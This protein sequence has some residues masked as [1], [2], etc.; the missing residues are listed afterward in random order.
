[1]VND[2]KLAASSRDDLGK[3]AARKLRAAGRIPA[4]VYGNGEGAQSLSLDGREVNRL[5]ANISIDNT[6]IH[7]TVDD[8]KPVRV[9]VR[10]VQR[11]PWRSEILHVD[12][13]QVRAGETVTVEVPVRLSGT[14]AGVR[15][16]GVLDQTLYD[17]AVRCRV[18]R[19]PEAIDID[20]SGLNVGDTLYVSDLSLPEGVE[21][22]VEG[23][24]VV[25]SVTP[26]T[27]SAVQE[28][29]EE[30]EAEGAAAGEATD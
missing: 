16:G 11:H 1:M 20:V 27:V 6:V 14:A 2:A 9:L 29:G 7:L 17:L 18:D 24:R 28:A 4:V 22:D 13:F 5:F 12:F 23:E 15:E 19:I 10:E 30:G 26:P 21:T 25:V 8:A 3:G